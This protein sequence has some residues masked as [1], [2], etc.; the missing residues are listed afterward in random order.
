[1]FTD[2]YGLLLFLGVQPYCKGLWWKRALYDHYINGDFVP[3]FNTIAQIMW[4]SCKADVIEEICIPKQ[5]E[6]TSWLQFSAVERHFYQQQ[7]RRLSTKTKTDIQ[8]RFPGLD[9]MKS[10]KL[11]DLSRH[12]FNY[13]L[14]PLLQLRQACIHPAVVRNGYLSMEK[15]CVTMD[16]VLQKLIDTT[17]LECEEAHRKLI[18]AMNGLAGV[19]LLREDVSSAVKCYQ[20]AM[21]SWESN[22]DINTDSLQV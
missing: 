4:R 1:M 2:I 14:H 21:K 17:K 16:Q 22:K 6:I 7:F 10:I 20:D 9:S 5:T 19:E 11:S 8:T 18:C 13:I 15:K 12:D 3:L